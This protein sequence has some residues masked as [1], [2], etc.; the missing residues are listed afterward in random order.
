VI[1]DIGTFASEAAPVVNRV[2]PTSTRLGGLS[3]SSTSAMLER[4]CLCQMRVVLI[5]EDGNVSVRLNDMSFEIPSIAAKR[6]S[7][8]L[9][10]AQAGSEHAPARVSHSLMLHESTG[11]LLVIR[12]KLTR[13]ERPIIPRASGALDIVKQRPLQV[14]PNRAGVLRRSKSVGVRSKVSSFRKN[15]CFEVVGSQ[16]WPR[17]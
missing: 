10:Q 14:Y 11:A 8:A 16:R 12:S 9:Q 4:I 6:R 13:I 1:M 5:R 17:Q 3:A 7:S 15:P 2:S